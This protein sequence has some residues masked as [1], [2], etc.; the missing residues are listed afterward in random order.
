ME[1]NRLAGIPPGLHAHRQT[2]AHR[3]TSL[4]INFVPVLSLAVETF[5]CL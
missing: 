1:K 3:M 5:S 2:D 4:Q